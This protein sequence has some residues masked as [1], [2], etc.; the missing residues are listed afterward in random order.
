MNKRD[1][2]L[3]EVSI[4]S[5]K[6][7]IPLSEL[8]VIDMTILDSFTIIKLND[9]TQD[10]EQIKNFKR[11]SKKV[12]E[13]NYQIHYS[14]GNFFGEEHLI[15]GI[16]SKLLEVDYFQG[17]TINN[18]KKIYEK[19]VLH[20]VVLFNSFEH[21]LKGKISDV[22]FKLDFQVENTEHFDLLTKHLESQSKPTLKKKEGVN[23]FNQSDNKGIEWNER[24]YSTYL[25]PY[26]KI[27]FKQTESQTL[28]K[29]DFFETFNLFPRTI[30]RAR[31]ETTV[32]RKQDLERYGITSNTLIGVLSTPK[33]ILSNIIQQSVNK[34][35]EPV[36]LPK[37]RMK[38]GM[39]PSDFFIVDSVNIRMNQLNMTFE[40]SLEN[41]LD[42]MGDFGKVQRSRT[43]KKI[44]DLY[45]VYI[46]DQVSEK[47]NNN[48]KIE[49]FY[50]LVGF[51]N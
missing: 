2:S 21:F 24:N 27:Y 45:K 3:N 30:N 19:I 12:K 47:E 22:D 34:V 6:Y 31:I 14:I 32:R 50:K 8:D 11:D 35:L 28:E 29:R 51:L 25:K 7:F 4:D 5:F 36:N 10:F 33:D 18:I 44:I 41:I 40:S 13:T 17:I 1:Y 23:R 20:N 9:R 46:K 39:S 15:I 38:Q 49:D 48:K 43:K 26:L 37:T 16:N 42:L